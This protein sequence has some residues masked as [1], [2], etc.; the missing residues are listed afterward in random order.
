M[1]HRDEKEIV[2]LLLSVLIGRVQVLQMNPFAVGFFAAVCSERL[3]AWSYALALSVGIW[4]TYGLLEMIKYM[5]VFIVCGGVS[6]A[7]RKQINVSTLLHSVIGASALYL[8]EYFWARQTTRLEADWMLLL[9]ESLLAGVFTQVLSLGIHHLLLG[10]KTKY[11]SNEELISL[12]VLGSLAIFGMP[13]QDALV[14]DTMQFCLV[15][16]ILYAG[17]RFGAGAGTLAGAVSGLFFLVNDKGVEILGILALLGMGAGVFRELGKL[18]SAL[19]F[20]GLYLVCGVYFYDDLL[21]VGKLRGLVVAGILFLLLPRRYSQKY[22]TLAGEDENGSG[23]MEQM[24]RQVRRRLE[25]FAEPFFELAN[26]FSKMSGPREDMEEEQMEAILQQVND[27]VCVGC[28]K[29][30]RCL[31]FTRHGKYRTASCIL[32][33]AREN[34]FL[35]VGDFPMNFV[36]K[37]DYVERYVAEANQALQFVCNDV[38]WQNRMAESRE[39]MGEQFQDIGCLLREFAYNLSKE[40]TVELEEKRELVYILRRNQVLVKQLELV[41]NNRNCLEIHLLAKARKR[42]CVT[43]RELAKCVS[44]VLGKAFTPSGQTRHVLAK[45]YERIVL[46]EDTKF[47]TISGVAR[48]QKKGEEVSGDNYSIVRLDNGE[49]VLTLADGMGSGEE[50]CQESTSVVELLESFLEAGVGERTAIHMINSSV[51]LRGK[52]QLS[53]LDMVILNLHNGNCE[54]IKMGASTAFVLHEDGVESIASASLPMGVFPKAQYENVSK[55]IQ[56]GDMIIL[57]SDGV[58]DAVDVEDQEGYYRNA[59]FRMRCDN[60]KELAD[61]ILQHAIENNQGEIVDDMTVL[62]TGVWKK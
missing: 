6:Y 17:Y 2:L 23:R 37:C 57:L 62:V 50:A 58:L 21:A 1:K 9:M 51:L 43:S 18:I 33:A 59:I 31:G 34:G 3:P 12:M 8:I 14:F 56:D 27:S 42:A 30:N 15:F 54:F 20:L 22:D 52:Q 24:E 55:K 61:R 26:I 10:R 36:N 45:E 40:Q 41:R 32:L 47:K 28:E 60:P 46:L 53:T 13:F 19:T 25:H 49:V 11:A 16:F 29:E 44:D 38:Q 39:A 4:N 5:L 7:L 35:S 48:Q